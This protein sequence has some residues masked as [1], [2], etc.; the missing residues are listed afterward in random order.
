[1]CVGSARL[2]FEVFVAI[3][4]VEGKVV[5]LTRGDMG[6]M[7]VYEDDPVATA[8]GW[9]AGGARWL[10]VVDLDQATGSGHDNTRTIE[11]VIKASPIPVEVGGGVRSVERISDWV[12]KGAARVCV[13]TK[14]LE[15]EFVAEAVREFSEQMVV[16]IDARGSVVQV[17]GWKT[18]SGRSWKETIRSVAELGAKRV[19]F[20]DIARD[21]T[22]AGPNLEAIEDVLAEVGG[23]M[24]VIAS[25]GVSAAED[26][27]SLAGLAPRGL[28]G[29]VVGRALYSGDVSLEAALAA[30]STGVGR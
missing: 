25:G 23:R 8:L 17:E 15:P 22:L 16:S 6:Q 20:T 4:I 5:R 18:S 10:H 11:A 30:C 7:T 26:I 27:A 28:E 21:G 2:S 14:S 12:Q 24:S 9:A 13:G 19:M 1:M 29:V 3:D